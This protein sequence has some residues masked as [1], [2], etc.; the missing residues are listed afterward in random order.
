MATMEDFFTC[1]VTDEIWWKPQQREVAML[2]S[3]SKEQRK[4]GVFRSL[5]HQKTI[6]AF[7]G[8]SH[9]VLHWLTTKTQNNSKYIF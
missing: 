1:K 9:L 3:D 5:S 6:E 7:F 8:L 2:A 4:E